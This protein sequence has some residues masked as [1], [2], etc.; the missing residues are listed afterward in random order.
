MEEMEFKEIMI[1]E[2]RLV[3][4][5][6]MV[7]VADESVGQVY[8]EEGKVSKTVTQRD[9]TRLDYGRDVARKVLIKAGCDPNSI[10]SVPEVVMGHPSGTVRVGDLLD[11]DLRTSIKNLYCCDTSVIPES[12]GV[13][14]TLTIISL[15]K[16]LS[17]HLLTIV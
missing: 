5:E 12:L 8:P 7:K 4:M 9:K 16:R 2:I 3:V 6:V 1:M 17:K 15:G 11:S 10:V 14:P 13:P